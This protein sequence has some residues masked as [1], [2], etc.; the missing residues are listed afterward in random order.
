MLAIAY[1]MGQS[2]SSS[3]NNSGRP[4][5]LT[6]PSCATRYKTD[7][8]RFASPGA[9]V[10]CAK[11]GHV[12]FHAIAE[13]EMEPEADIIARPPEPHTLGDGVLAPQRDTVTTDSGGGRMGK[14]HWASV[15]AWASLVIFIAAL[16]WA[17]VTYRQTIAELWP[18]AA[19]FYA[20]IGM[21]LNVRGLAFEDVSHTVDEEE[22]QRLLSITG[23]IAN[24]GQRELPIP[25]VKISL[26]DAER[27][28][29]Y[30]WDFEVGVATLKPGETASFVQRLTNP[31]ATATFVDVRFQL[32]APNAAAHPES[33][34]PPEHAPA[35]HEPAEH[36]P[37]EPAPAEH[38]A[39][40]PAPTPAAPVAPAAH[41]EPPAAAAPH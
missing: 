14:I 24:I 35:E 7:R 31:P 16:A 10:R 36:A 39:A 34:A 13:A 41:A 28:E 30:A 15:G 1:A 18:N 32:D 11:C 33:S 4:M 40:E 29:L 3:R 6:C 26:A 23:K 20:A 19:S 12:W 38:E 25:S 17:V 21:P 9:N 37:A 2:R 22:G 5:I 8:A 27:H